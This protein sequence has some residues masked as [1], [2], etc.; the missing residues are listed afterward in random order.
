MPSS[1]FGL[2]I[3]SSGMGAYS[4]ALNTTAHNIANINTTGYSKQTALQ[5]AK[6]AI[7]LKTHYGMLGAGTIVT[8]IVSSRDEYYDNKYRISNAVYGRYSTLSYYMQNLEDYLYVVDE[9]T[10]GL[11]NSL[12]NFFAALTSL[13]RD[14]SDATIRA[15]AT[16]YA[17]TMV[18]FINELGNNLQKMQ[19]EINT[20]IKNAVDRINSY[21]QQ[22]ASV[23]KQI[24]SLEVY[25]S[26]AND[27]RDKRANLL[28]E[29]SQWV[30]IS[31][32]E[33][34]PADGQGVNQFIV[35]ITG[36]GILVDTNV[37]NQIQA[38]SSSTKDN[39]N[40]I[41]GLYT[42]QWSNGQDFN[43]HSSILGGNLQALFEMRDGNNG[44]NFKA[45]FTS[46]SQQDNNFGGKATITLKTDGNSSDCASNLS[47]LNIPESDGKISIANYEYEYESFQVKVAAD[48]S[49]EY[50]FVLK[51]EMTNGAAEHLQTALDSGKDEAAIGEEISF[52]GIPYYMSQLNEFARVLSANFN[53]IQNQGYDLYGNRGGDLLIATG[54]T[55]GEEFD[56]TE[57]L[58]NKQDN[59]YYLNGC[60]VLDSAKQA[61]FQASG[62][63]FEAVDGEDGYFWLVNAEGEQE[64]K[65]YLP[66]EDSA[67]FTFNSLTTSGE[68]TS[69]Y[70]ITALNFKASEKM[71]KDGNYL[72][73]AK[74][75]PTT[76]SGPSE[77]LNLDEMLKLREDATMFK[78][79]D[80]GS[81]LAIMTTTA[82]VDGAK[83][84]DNSESA[85]DVLE[86]VG[87]RR[88]SKSGVDEDEEGQNLI[89]FQNLLNYQY[90]VISIMNE[91]LDKLINETGV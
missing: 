77:A 19:D 14:A 38:V 40:D 29:L 86:A 69:Y 49:Y 50:T 53:Q 90:R 37:A 63:T 8:E 75:D 91:V 17:D 81:F 3:A 12:D 25:G 70:S 10:G 61:E 26:P 73:L 62:Y 5:Q 9:E 48:G 60:K 35:S 11:T 1:F 85:E 55:T 83:L 36:G 56:M 89:I 51:E 42:L 82:G 79:G 34:A 46:Y 24:N 64:E 4:A 16:G 74:G 21:A 45:T 41:D 57:F 52:R 76:T 43:V 80:P 58:F 2:T 72:A 20:E 15:E 13:S 87:N 78:Q 66:D 6:N 27:L 54:N 47:K 39:Q 30:D 23:T 65:V 18:T 22:I 44:E 68:S 7:S 67:I 32:V 28:D 31:V 71:V 33:Q 59:Y 88:L 84:N